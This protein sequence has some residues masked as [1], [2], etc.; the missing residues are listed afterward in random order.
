MLHHLDVRGTLCD[1][2]SGG[3]VPCPDSSV[4]NPELDL[5]GHVSTYIFAWRGLGSARRNVE[6]DGSLKARW[7]GEVL[8]LPFAGFVH[9]LQS[10]AQP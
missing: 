9:T 1:Q 7:Q 3:P 4:I 6:R 5:C 2:H 8:L 10:P